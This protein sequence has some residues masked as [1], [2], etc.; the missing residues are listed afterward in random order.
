MAYYLGRWYA[1][2]PIGT[3][4]QGTTFAGGKRYSLTQFCIPFGAGLKVNIAKRA[5]LA[6][7]WGLRKTFTDYMDDVSGKYVDPFLLASE[8][9]PVAAALSDRS[10]VKEGGNNTGR[11]RGNAYTKDWY[12]F[13]GII[14]T[15]KLKKDEEC[16]AP[17]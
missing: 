16:D 11:Q 17:H 6:L 2:Q 9:G 8:R 15:F 14:F 12:S 3:E 5:S 4:G 7:E 10:L 1:L 13:A